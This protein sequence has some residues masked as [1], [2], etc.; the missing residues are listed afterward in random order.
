MKKITQIAKSLK[1]K[2]ES[3]DEIK[4]KEEN[5]LA[6]FHEYCPEGSQYYDQLLARFK[7]IAKKRKAKAVRDDEEEGDD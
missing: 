7:K 3:I 4:A 5:L 1:D 6:K 2:K